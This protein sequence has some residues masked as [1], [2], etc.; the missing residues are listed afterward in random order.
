MFIK[1]G[2]Q[3][4]RLKRCWFWAKPVQQTKLQKSKSKTEELKLFCKNNL[5]LNIFLENASIYQDVFLFY[6]MTNASFLDK[7][8]TG[9]IQ[10]FNLSNTIVVLQ[11]NA[12]KYF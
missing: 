6:K 8:A 12:P 7:I 9:S 1:K 11:I 5:V 3:A 10:L 2:Y 4:D